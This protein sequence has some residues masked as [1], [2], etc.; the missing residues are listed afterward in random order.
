MPDQLF[1]G[2]E[3]RVSLRFRIAALA[4]SRTMLVGGTSHLKYTDWCNRLAASTT[5]VSF[6]QFA[7]HL[8]ALVLASIID[9]T[10]ETFMA[11]YYPEWLRLDLNI[12]TSSKN[13][14]SGNLA[15]AEQI[16]A[17]ADGTLG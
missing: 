6:D 9:S 1:A 11:V 8:A 2:D 17:L 10:A 16:R 5:L 12:A 4:R 13:V 14:F 7:C 3:G 15:L